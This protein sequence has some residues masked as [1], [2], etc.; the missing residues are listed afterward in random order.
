MNWGLKSGDGTNL[1]FPRIARNN[2]IT[3]SQERWFHLN[4]TLSWNILDY[5]YVNVSFVSPPFSL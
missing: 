1:P 3:V 4:V 2:A 5:H